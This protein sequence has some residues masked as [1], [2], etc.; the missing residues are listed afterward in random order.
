MINKLID[1]GLWNKELKNEIIE[2]KGS[3]QSITRIP[4]DIRKV[5][6]TAYE[7]HPKTIIEQAVDRGAFVCQSQSM[8]IFLDDPDI[9]KLSN[10]HFYSWKQGLKT[11]IYYLRTRPVARVQSF[12]LEA[13]KYEKA[14]E[15]C[16]NCSA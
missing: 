5:F 10:M 12:S 1:L 13:K 15:E 2:N 14:P 11:G 16:I 8:N 7:I 6:K 4:E 9:T 3:I